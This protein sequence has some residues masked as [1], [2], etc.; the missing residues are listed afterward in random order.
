MWP[1]LSCASEAINRTVPV[2]DWQR[3]CRA[4]LAVK[5]CEGDR[6]RRASAVAKQHIGSHQQSLATNDRGRPSGGASICTAHQGL[7]SGRRR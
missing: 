4:A 2:L 7:L 3:L 1:L 6:G 5:A